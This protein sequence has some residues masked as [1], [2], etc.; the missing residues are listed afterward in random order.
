MIRHKGT[1]AHLTT[2]KMLHHKKYTSIHFHVR[3][4]K[5]IKPLMK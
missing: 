2:S 4:N 5:N 1:D 3:E